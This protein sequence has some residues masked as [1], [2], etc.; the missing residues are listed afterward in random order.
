LRIEGLE[1]LR[2]KHEMDSIGRALPPTD[3]TA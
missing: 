2:I 3:K 1:R